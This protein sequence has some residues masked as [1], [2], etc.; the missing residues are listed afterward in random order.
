MDTKSKRNK[1]SKPTKF[2][3]NKNLKHSE[4][5]CLFGKIIFANLFYYSVYFYYYLW[6]LMHFLVLFIVLTN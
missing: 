3:Y 4:R 1:I 5:K 6:V 2:V